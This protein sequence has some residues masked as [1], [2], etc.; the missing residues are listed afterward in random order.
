MALQEMYRFKRRRLWLV[1]MRKHRCY[2]LSF[3]W[4]PIDWTVV[5]KSPNDHN[6]VILCIFNSLIFGV[7]FL[8]T[9]IRIFITAVELIKTFLWYVEH[10]S[11]D[12]HWSESGMMSATLMLVT[13]LCWT[14]FIRNLSQTYFVFNIRHLHDEKM[15]IIWNIWHD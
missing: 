10:E 4:P 1:E 3:A 5:L 15:E 11:A 6:W 12:F 8:L 2:S 7:N 14:F 13:Q 9:G